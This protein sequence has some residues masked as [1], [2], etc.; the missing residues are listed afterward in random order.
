MKF[1]GEVPLE[2]KE[3]GKILKN[4]D[5]KQGR[6]EKKEGE[7]GKDE[8]KLIVEQRKKTT[9]MPA[10]LTGISIAF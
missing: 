10:L 4:T 7:K 1:A 2:T 8:D 9:F 6:R 3:I 5:I